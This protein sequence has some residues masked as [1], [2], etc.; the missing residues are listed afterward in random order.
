M[1]GVLSRRSG[2][3]HGHTRVS[4]ALSAASRHHQL[5]FSTLSIRSG[6]CELTN[7][8]IPTDFPFLFVSLP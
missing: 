8:A 5:V 1:N 6:L 3:G 7:Y 4:F 2:L